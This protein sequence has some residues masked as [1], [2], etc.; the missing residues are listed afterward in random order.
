MRIMTQPK[1][2]DLFLR[3]TILVAPHIRKAID[4]PHME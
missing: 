3:T 2:P 4:T 1:D